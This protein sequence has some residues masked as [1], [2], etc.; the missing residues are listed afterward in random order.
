MRL[1]LVSRSRLHIARCNI[2]A[3][4]GNLSNATLS[5]E[6]SSNGECGLVNCWVHLQKD[7]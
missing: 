5:D 4:A 3:W 7:I 1:L 2:V 6:S